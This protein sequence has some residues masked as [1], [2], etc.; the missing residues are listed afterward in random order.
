WYESSSRSRDLPASRALVTSLVR[1]RCEALAITRENVLLCG[2][3]QGGVTSLDVALADPS[4]AVR[5]ACLSGYLSVEDAPAGRAPDLRVFMGHGTEDDLI[6][7]ERARSAR[8]ELEARGVDVTF[9]E[10]AMPHTIVPEEIEH[11]RTWLAS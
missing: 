11:L 6:P 8:R 3:S 4:L 7:I 5:V 2:F 9:R 10:Y 1:S